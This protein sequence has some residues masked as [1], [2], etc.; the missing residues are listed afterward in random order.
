MK[1]RLQALS[2]LETQVAELR[3]AMCALDVVSGATLE[4]LKPGNGL[5]ISD[6]AVNVF[7]IYALSDEEEDA[8]RHMLTQVGNL[9]LRLDREFHAALAL[10]AERAAA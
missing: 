4:R 7:H 8:L 9:V 5:A 2:A 1:A 6:N 3:C 10:N